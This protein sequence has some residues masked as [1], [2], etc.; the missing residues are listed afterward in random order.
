MSNNLSLEKRYNSIDISRAL[1]IVC[2]VTVHTFIFWSK[3][4]FSLERDI[5]YFIGGLA[6]PFFLITSGISFYILLTK[7]IYENRLK[8]EIFVIV[9]KRAIFI[10][11]VSTLFQIFFGSYFGMKI[12]FI[13][14]W[15]VFQVIAFSMILFFYIPFFKF[16]IR[17]A[18]YFLA[19]SIIFLLD[20]IINFYEIELLF[21][22][23][24]GTFEFIPYANFFLLGVFISDLIINLSESQFNKILLVF[25]LLGLLSN[26]FLFILGNLFKSNYFS[27]VLKF[28]RYT[29]IFLIIFSISF[30]FTDIKKSDFIFKQI[31]IKWGKLSFSLYYIHF[32]LLGIAYLFYPL[33]FNNSILS[34]YLIY[35]YIIL[36]LLF[37][38]IYEITLRIWKKFDYKFGL[39]WFMNIF[40]K[41]SLFI[42]IKNMMSNKNN[43][44]D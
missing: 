42:N 23:V 22:L 20:F 26:L 34:G 6:A 1:A 44:K 35:E 21:L 37:F 13:I 18:V 27:F 38:L 31:L 28:I 14:Y 39:E 41:K 4:G 40:V 30:Y 2:M 43:I 33:L 17:L 24:E 25:I 19:I 8:K 29:G 9:L 15:S 36:L 12:S 32:I 11:I 3:L 5:V 10:F 7:K 16:K